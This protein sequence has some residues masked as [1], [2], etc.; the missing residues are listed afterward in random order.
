MTSKTQTERLIGKWQIDDVGTLC[1]LKIKIEQKR[2]LASFIFEG[3]NNSK[4]FK[5]C[6]VIRPE[7]APLKGCLLQDCSL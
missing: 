3:E 4:T 7:R 2:E 5:N 1:L 6:L